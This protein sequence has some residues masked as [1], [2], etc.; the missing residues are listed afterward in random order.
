MVR[1]QHFCVPS[2]RG[3]QLILAGLAALRGFI[4]P[5][6]DRSRLSG[7]SS[8]TR[9]VFA[10]ALLA[11]LLLPMQ[12]FLQS[13]PTV[14]VDEKTPLNLST[15]ISDNVS[16]EIF[17]TVTLH[18]ATST[19]RMPTV[20]FHY[21][22]AGLQETVDEDG[23][24]QSAT[25]GTGNPLHNQVLGNL[26]ITVL[27][28]G[29]TPQQIMTLYDENEPQFETRCS[30]QSGQSAQCDMVNNPVPRPQRTITF[31]TAFNE[32]VS[33]II[34]ARNRNGF[35]GLST[36]R[37]SATAIQLEDDRHSTELVTLQDITFNWEASNPPV[38]VPD[39]TPAF[40]DTIT[41]TIGQ[42]DAIRMPFAVGA[43]ESFVVRASVSTDPT[44]EESLSLA[45]FGIGFAESTAVRITPAFKAA[46]VGAFNTYY[47]FA[48]GL[49][50]PF[51][52]DPAD[53]LNALPPLMPPGCQTGCNEAYG[54]A[55]TTL[56]LTVNGVYAPGARNNAVVT[57]TS[58]VSLYARLQRPGIAAGGSYTVHLE[59]LPARASASAIGTIQY[60]V[61]ATDALTANS[62]VATILGGGIRPMREDDDASVVTFRVTLVGGENDD[63]NRITL[64]EYE[65]PVFGTVGFS[66]VSDSAA[67]ISQTSVTVRNVAAN[68]YSRNRIVQYRRGI[69]V[70]EGVYTLG[71]LGYLPAPYAA[72]IAILGGENAFGRTFN[73]TAYA[74]VLPSDTRRDNLLWCAPDISADDLL[75]DFTARCENTSVS[76]ATIGM[77]LTTNNPVSIEVAAVLL[78]EQADALF[79]HATDPAAD[80]SY[81]LSNTTVNAQLLNLSEEA[82]EV[83]DIGQILSGSP[84]FSNFRTVFVAAGT[85][86]L[87]NSVRGVIPIINFVPRPGIE[88]TWES[89]IVVS[90][91]DISVTLA[92]L[93]VSI[94][95]PLLFDVLDFDEAETTT[96]FTVSEDNADGLL[97]AEFTILPSINIISGNMDVI[98]RWEN[99][100]Q[101]APGTSDGERGEV[102]ASPAV[103]SA[104]PEVL[105]RNSSILMRVPPSILVGDGAGTW[106]ADLF[107]RDPRAAISGNIR[108]ARVTLTVTREDDPPVAI[109]AYIYSPSRRLM[110]ILPMSA[111][112]FL[113]SSRAHTA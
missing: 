17:H 14:L 101:Y 96:Q 18:Q 19:I 47:D 51:A 56:S 80:W 100:Q 40:G 30:G 25:E 68:D 23:N 63:V 108:L 38:F 5:D 29:D 110:S 90:G 28:S 41:V 7:L 39:V 35:N 95:V 11:L 33:A 107:I 2:R 89:D 93:S 83:T 3:F 13:G 106:E 37:F 76:I 85:D 52:P 92:R 59:V 84:A 1:K 64:P 36:V 70:W 94:D 105:Y 42:A 24:L 72:S 102:L 45:Q 57:T 104:A 79:R 97:P 91:A 88:G 9:V 99:Q 82:T 32:R 6:P 67:I 31:T 43:P 73:T 10:L 98:T 86:S 15:G 34:R 103:L 48:Q 111:G 61:T 87:G 81:S 109:S 46:Q 20:T 71:A 16:Q 54:A 8:G 22:V 75:S 66:L 12:A 113:W 69:G 27:G 78:A 4:R 26:R 49:A 44:S 74:H 60:V 112:L 21:E 58:T 50:T 55:D 77:T 62:N 65:S 53:P